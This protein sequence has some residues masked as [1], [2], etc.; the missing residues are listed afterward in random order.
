MVESSRGDMLRDVH[1][2]RS[3]SV[4]ILVLLSNK[5]LRI[6]PIQSPDHNIL[7]LKVSGHQTRF[8]QVVSR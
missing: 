8:E 5:R 3:G 6:F 1:P 7:H 2:F 4:F